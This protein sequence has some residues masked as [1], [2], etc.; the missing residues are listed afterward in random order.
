MSCLVELESDLVQTLSVQAIGKNEEGR[1]EG[2]SV[3][4]F[5]LI[6]CIPIKSHPSLSPDFLYT[7]C[8]ASILCD[9]ISDPISHFDLYPI[10]V[11]SGRGSS[12]N[13]LNISLPHFLAKMVRP[14]SSIQQ[15]TCS[16][17][18]AYS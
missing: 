1:R 2:S 14:D 17:V 16:K 13:I 18:T 3:D 10:I 12:T 15:S 11:I 5:F 4:T 8:I 9:M 6:D 7:I